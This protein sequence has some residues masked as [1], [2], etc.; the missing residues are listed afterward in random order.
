[1]ADTQAVDIMILMTGDT[2]LIPAL[3]I[4]RTRGFQVA[5]VNLPNY[6]L[7]DELKQ[8]VDLFRSVTW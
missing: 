4:V 3:K 8:H 2:D 1:M 7:I 6:V 5:G